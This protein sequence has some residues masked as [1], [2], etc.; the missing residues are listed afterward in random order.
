MSRDEPA[1][2]PQWQMLQKEFS[3]S[4]LGRMAAE[5]AETIDVSY[6]W[7]IRFQWKLKMVLV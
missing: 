2:V 5:Q 6:K 7:E 3:C 4:E 1:V